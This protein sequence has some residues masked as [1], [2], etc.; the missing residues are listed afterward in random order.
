M[1]DKEVGVIAT[2]LKLGIGK[3]VLVRDYER[4]QIRFGHHV[5]SNG[6]RGIGQVVE[7]RIVLVK[8]REKV[9]VGIAYL[10]AVHKSCLND[11]RQGQEEP[12]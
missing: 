6:R 11:Q 5:H 8:I 9:H 3:A 4:D 7:G 10:L 2:E 1:I 12:C